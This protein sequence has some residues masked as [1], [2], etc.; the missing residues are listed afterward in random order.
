VGE[1]TVDAAPT[2]VSASAHASEV[3][4]G[5]EV[6]AD[7]RTHEEPG[8]NEGELSS[9]TAT[10]EIAVAGAVV[11]MFGVGTSCDEEF[12]VDPDCV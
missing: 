11:T 3:L 1:V 8:T 6:E 5:F 2:V 9:L 12:E 10:M 4:P 7:R